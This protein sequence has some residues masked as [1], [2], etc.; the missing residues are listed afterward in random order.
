LKSVQ[1][2]GTGRREAKGLISVLDMREVVPSSD[3]V[4][5]ILILVNE[6][7]LLSDKA[8]GRNINQVAGEIANDRMGN[9]TATPEVCEIIDQPSSDG[10][11]PQREIAKPVNV[12]VT[13]I[14]GRLP[15]RSCKS[16][17]GHGHG[18]MPSLV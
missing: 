14:R 2:L 12:G 11:I 18:L 4:K 5:L 9:E 3:H 8:T 17:K 1:G 15:A 10:L 6:K 13:I 16:L 7:P